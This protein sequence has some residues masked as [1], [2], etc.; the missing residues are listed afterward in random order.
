MVE[1]NRELEVVVV[2][3]H[4]QQG[5]DAFYWCGLREM[6]RMGLVVGTPGEAL[7]R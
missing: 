7:L 1:T 3:L 4:Y 2:V 5:E 6:K